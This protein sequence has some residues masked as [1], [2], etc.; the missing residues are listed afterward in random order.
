MLDELMPREWVVTD[1][2]N[3]QDVKPNTPGMAMREMRDI[4]SG[5]EQII[6]MAI[7]ESIRDVVGD[8]IGHGGTSSPGAADPDPEVAAD[9][10]PNESDGGA[11][12][13]QTAPNMDGPDGDPDP[14][15]PDGDPDVTT[16]GVKNQ[17]ETYS[18]TTTNAATTREVITN[19]SMARPSG[20]EFLCVDTPV[21]YTHLTLPTSDLV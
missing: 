16:T 20:V 11:D 14:G 1:E 10:Q 6:E 13:G 17:L 21:S 5:A 12:L 18:H 2:A 8:V 3:V 7:T 9:Q 19:A 15:D 4:N